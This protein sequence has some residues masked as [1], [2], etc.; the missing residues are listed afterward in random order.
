[1]NKLQVNEHRRI[2][3]SFPLVLDAALSFDR[4]HN[5]WL[6]RAS[7]H[8][9][10]I[11]PVA[12]GS[13]SIRALRSGATEPEVVERSAAWVAAALL[14]YCFKRRIPIPRQGNKRIELVTDAIDLV[15]A[16]TVQVL[17]IEL[18]TSEA[19][20]A[21]AATAGGTPERLEANLAAQAAPTD[22]AD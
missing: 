9:L 17:P 10:T 3:F 15:I 6:W 21:P 14:H 7:G 11:A 2:T 22:K 20:R 18:Q 8:A 1:M 19:G 13:L 12:D 4:E 16:T 5:G